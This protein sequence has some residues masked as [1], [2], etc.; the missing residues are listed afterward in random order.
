MQ[1]DA[2]FVRR[3]TAGR[4]PSAADRHILN[5]LRDISPSKVIEIG[6]GPGIIAGKAGFVSDYICTDISFNFLKVASEAAHSSVYINCTAEALPVRNSSADCVIAMAV[7]H[8]LGTDNLESALNEIHRVLKPGGSFLLLEDWC[9]TDGV[10]EF[11]E[12]AKEWRFR[13]GDSENHMLAHKWCEKI[14]D[15]GFSC[16]EPV[17][18]GRPFSSWSPDLLKWPEE[19]RIVRMMALES[20]KTS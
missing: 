18:V 12:R 15:A 2:E 6:C 14:S 13:N 4:L 9:F 5:R 7:L 19:D 17:S 10:T 20:V 8:H 1:W 11:E 3:Y 16:G